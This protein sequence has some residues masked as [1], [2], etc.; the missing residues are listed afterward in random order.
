MIDYCR[1]EWPDEELV[2]YTAPPLVPS[3][4]L[5]AVFHPAPAD[6]H[7]AAAVAA[8]TLPVESPPSRPDVKFHQYL[9][10]ASPALLCE[11]ASVGI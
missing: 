11:L 6:G 3:G 4:A 9:T 5:A 7:D 10:H 8:A 2:A 1:Y